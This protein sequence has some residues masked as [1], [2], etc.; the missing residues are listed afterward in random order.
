MSGSIGGEAV[1]AHPEPVGDQADSGE[2]REALGRE[3]VL[4]LEKAPS[5]LRLSYVADVEDEKLVKRRLEAVKDEIAEAWE[6][7]GGSY[8]L[9][10][11][12]EVFWR[13]GAP[14]EKPTAKAGGRK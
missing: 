7:R 10:I 13:R 11:E 2:E 4:V 9:T 12:P 5:T 14:P 1:A 6:S 3:R 8:R